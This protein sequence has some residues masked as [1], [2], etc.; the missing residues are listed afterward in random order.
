MEKDDFL[1]KKEKCTFVNENAEKVNK[2][3]KTGDFKD[4]CGRMQKNGRK[5]TYGA[6]NRVVFYWGKEM[7]QMATSIQSIGGE[8]LP[9]HTTSSWEA[10]ASAAGPFLLAAGKRGYTLIARDNGRYYTLP[11]FTTEEGVARAF[12]EFLK[13]NHVSPCHMMDIWQDQFLLQ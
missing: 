6:K 7:T 3:A 1:N 12:V 5:S 8:D 9:L 11:C 10:P 13:D 2:N 4:I